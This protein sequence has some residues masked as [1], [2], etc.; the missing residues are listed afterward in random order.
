[1]ALTATSVA[2]SL[3]IEPS[4]RSKGTPLAAIQEARQVSKRAASIWVAKSANGKAM[5]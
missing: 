2:A 5:P 4:A 3:D 1:M